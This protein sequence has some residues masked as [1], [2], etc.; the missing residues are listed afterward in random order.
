[1]PRAGSLRVLFAAAAG[2]RIGFGHLVRCRSIAGALGIPPVVAIRGTE[3]THRRAASAGWRVVSARHDRDLGAFEPDVLVVDD[4]SAA[5][6]SAWVRRARTLGVPV[7]TVHDLG[8]G[9]VASDLVIDGTIAPVGGETG[10]FGTLRGLEYA[11]L[12][13]Q[14]HRQRHKSGSTP[15]ILIALGGGRTATL[16][17]RLTRALATRLDGVVFRVTA[18]FVPPRRLP[19]L[20]RGR[21]IAVPNGLAAELSSA[22]VAIVGGGV[23]L[24]EACALGVPTVAVALN[25]AQHVNVRAL[26]KRGATIDG[27]IARGPEGPPLHGPRLR[28]IVRAIEQ[29]L[30]DAAARR[31]LAVAGRTLVDGHGVFRV[32]ARLRQLP[33]LVSAE[34]SHVA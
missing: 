4:P 15:R 8:I 26:A 33:G 16:A 5:A 31:R 13:P 28:R 23:T 25:A 19:A 29:L 14:V 3:A 30:G 17:T 7:A 18:G 10:R 9:A 20:P 21:W 32:A 24:Y 11:I 2:P 34:I 22:T 6:A 27:G 1:M 12:D